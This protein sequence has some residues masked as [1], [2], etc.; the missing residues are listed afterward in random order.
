VAGSLLVSAAQFGGYVCGA[1]IDF[2]MIH[3][4]TRPVRPNH[5][6]NKFSRLIVALFDNL[7]CS[8]EKG[9]RRM[10]QKQHATIQSLLAVFG[11]FSR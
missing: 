6:V 3:A 5:K 4:K 7:I 10:H 8:A 9:Q 2:L 11:Y 1:D